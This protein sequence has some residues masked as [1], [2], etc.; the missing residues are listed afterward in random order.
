MKRHDF[1]QTVAEFAMAD[2]KRTNILPSLTVAQAI[3]ESNWGLSGLA[4][5]ANNLFGIKGTYEGK[6]ENFETKEYYGGKWVTITAQFRKYPSFEGSVKDHND[7]LQKTRY[8]SVRG[9]KDYKKACYAIWAAGYATDPKY[10]DKLI[11]IIEKFK[12]YEYDERVTY[13]M[14]KADADIIIRILQ[15][16]WQ[17]AKTPEEKKEIGRLANELR[18][19]SGQKVQ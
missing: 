7:L 14:A 3:L 19:A 4:T 16:K 1:L 6:G 9:E 5:K 13:M 17:E 2:Y 10:P 8:K 18:K 11:A 12:L 15:I